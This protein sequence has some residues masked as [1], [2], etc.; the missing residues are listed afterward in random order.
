MFPSSFEAFS[1]KL[2][3]LKK[4]FAVRTS[5]DLHILKGKLERRCLQT[6]VSWRV[7][8]HEPEINVNDMAGLYTMYANDKAQESVEI[9][10][11]LLDTNAPFAVDEDVAVVSILD[12]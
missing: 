9:E 6:D 7:A 12:L 3:E 5:Q 2:L 1:E 10:R 4:Y 11:D 8:E